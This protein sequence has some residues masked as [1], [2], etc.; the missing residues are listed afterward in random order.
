MSKI[1]I[2]YNEKEYTLEFTRDTVKLMEQSGFTI[3]ELGDRPVSLM[4]R[5]FAGAFQAHHPRLSSRVIQEIFDHLNNK[6]EMLTALI[7]MYSAPIN[8]LF[9]DADGAEGNAAWTVIS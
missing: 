7:E 3:S 1:N 5:L 9:D 2:T 6:R 4:P 8:S